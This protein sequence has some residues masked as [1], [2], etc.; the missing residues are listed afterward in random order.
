MAEFNE[1]AASAVKQMSQVEPRQPGRSVTQDVD[2]MRTNIR[3]LFEEIEALEQYLTPIL[4]DQRDAL[5]HILPEA[6]AVGTPGLNAEVIF[7][8]NSI[9][10]AANRLRD[11]RDSLRL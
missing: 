7:A 4:P 6:P 1:Q 11:L 3:V 8:D 5:A 10:D 2:G 9:V